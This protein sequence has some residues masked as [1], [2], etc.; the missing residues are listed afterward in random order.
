MGERRQRHTA[1]WT[2]LVAGVASALLCAADVCSAGA[3]SAT[4]YD[5][6]VIVFAPD[7]APAQVA[8]S[9]PRIMDHEVVTEAIRELGRQTGALIGEV[10]IRD[11]QRARGMP[12]EGTAAKFMA[13]GLLRWHTG[14]LPVGPIIRSLPAWS[15]MRLV[16]IVGEN[17]SFSGPTD[18]EAEGFVVRFVNRM[19][20]Y[21][22]DV[23]RKTGRVSPRQ[24]P[25]EEGKLSGALLP[26][27]LIGLPAG[28][29]VGWLLGDVRP[30][31]RA[32]TP[33]R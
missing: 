21:E 5:L 18:T 23:E 9:Y 27:A 1:R 2:A 24:A 16:F 29:I 8:L 10:E 11:E 12:A 13:P 22:Y 14:A 17:A 30:R 33:S 25:L 6:T 3:P 15:R 28:L 7:T 31:R 32:P 26:T 4:G 20:P 19:K